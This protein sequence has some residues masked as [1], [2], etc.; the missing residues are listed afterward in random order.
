LL[1]WEGWG[2]LQRALLQ[3]VLADTAAGLKVYLQQMDAAGS[4]SSIGSSSSKGSSNSGSSSSSSSSINHYNITLH[5][6][7]SLGAELPYNPQAV[8]AAAAAAPPTIVRLPLQPPVVLQPLSTQPS[9]T[10]LAFSR[11]GKD[12]CL[13][14]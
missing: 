9:T 6:V 3:Q 8:A 14:G 7:S 4:S 5:L 11:Q 13:Q 1:V 12:G 10:C 2:Q